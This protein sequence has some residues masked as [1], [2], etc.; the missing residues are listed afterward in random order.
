M[1]L[2]QLF[3]ILDEMREFCQDY[4]LQCS[5]WSHIGECRK[6]VQ[7][8]KDNC[9]MSCGFCTEQPRC[10]IKKD[11]RIPCSAKSR[12]HCIMKGCCWRKDGCYMP[13]GTKKLKKH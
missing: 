1:L 5:E 10:D 3:H 12:D 2:Y 13:I 7:F 11:D 8:M 6:N 4:D 9:P